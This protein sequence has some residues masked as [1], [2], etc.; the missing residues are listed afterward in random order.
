[1]RVAFRA[2]ASTLIGSGHIARCLTLANALISYKV[3][4]TFICR[5]HSGHLIEAIKKNGHRVLTLPNLV[6]G[7]KTAFTA[8]SYEQWLGTSWQADALDTLSITAHDLFDWLIVDHYAL[9]AQWENATA[10]CYERL[11]VIDDLTDRAH[12]CDLFL[13][14]NLGANTCDY[15]QLVPRESQRLLGPQYALL[16]P[17]FAANRQRSINRRLRTQLDRLLICFGGV[18]VS[19]ATLAVL[20]Q[21]D[22]VPIPAH[23]S[24]TI[25]MGS[26]SP[27]LSQVKTLAS[28]MQRNSTVFVD[29][30]NMAHLLSESDLAIGSAGGMALERCCL[31]LPS[32]IFIVAQNQKAGAEALKA[33][34]AALVFDSIDEVPLLSQNSYLLDSSLTSLRSV[35]AKA[36]TV[37]DGLG[38]ARVLDKLLH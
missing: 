29:V 1:M 8:E 12:V 2:D 30:E 4:S 9:D 24:I 37:C 36:S 35:G 33:R 27:T 21:L 23:T 13:N 19:G 26:Q 7:A 38:V 10:R 34:G 3:E 15:Q 11:M 18:D 32:L 28:N 16:R 25:I 14:Q 6:P 17:E 20:E 5:P 22:S 31:G